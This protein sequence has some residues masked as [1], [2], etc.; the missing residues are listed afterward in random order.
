MNELYVICDIRT[1]LPILIKLKNGAPQIGFTNKLLAEKYIEARKQT[2]EVAAINV[3]D[4]DLK[5]NMGIVIEDKESAIKLL[6]D[7]EHFVT[8]Q[9]YKTFI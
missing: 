6:T 4:I 2:K 7:P 1:Y 3:Q 8:E 9:Y 5:D